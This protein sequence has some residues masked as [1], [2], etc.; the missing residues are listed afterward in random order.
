MTVNLINIW[1]CCL[2][3]EEYE[4]ISKLILYMRLNETN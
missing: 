2:G 3:E 4:I 1:N